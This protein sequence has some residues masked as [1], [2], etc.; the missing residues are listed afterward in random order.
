M[1]KRANSKLLFLEGRRMVELITERFILT[2]DGRVVSNFR[3]TEGQTALHI[4]H[5]VDSIDY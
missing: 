3:K 5:H 4:I 2:F 1:K